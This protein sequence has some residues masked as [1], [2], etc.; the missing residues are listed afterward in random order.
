MSRRQPPP[1]SHENESDVVQ[2]PHVAWTHKELSS[3]FQ[4]V[5][6]RVSD[7]SRCRVYGVHPSPS[8][9]HLSWVSLRFSELSVWLVTLILRYNGGT[10]CFSLEPYIISIRH[11]L[12]GNLREIFTVIKYSNN[13]HSLL[14]LISYCPVIRERPCPGRLPNTFF[15][16]GGGWIPGYPGQVRWHLCESSRH[17]S[18]RTALL[19]QPGTRHW[20]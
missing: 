2:L 19:P 10:G 17:P 1:G 7:L 20:V 9:Q 8:L 12:Q 3:R 14:R 6:D 16:K 4:S 18:V 15:R 11:E 5:Q 13:S